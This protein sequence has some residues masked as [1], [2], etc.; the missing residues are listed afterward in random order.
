MKRRYLVFSPMFLSLSLSVFAAPTVKKTDE[1]V[2]LDCVGT[3]PVWVRSWAERP[4]GVDSD[5]AKLIVRLNLSAHT[6][7]VESLFGSD[8]FVFELN[9]K[10][11]WYYGA[12]K[13]SLPHLD[14]QV[15]SSNISLNRINGAAHIGFEVA[16]STNNGSK[17]AFDG[18][19]E[20][21]SVKF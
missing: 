18:T 12:G 6:A 14:G 1:I 5:K 9:S 2:Y 21:G 20:R 13:R 19:C 8:E 16:A 4:L 11:D 3:R 7:T 17:F 10:P 15:V